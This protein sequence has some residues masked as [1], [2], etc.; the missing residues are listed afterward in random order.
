MCCQRRAREDCAYDIDSRGR[1]GLEREMEGEVDGWLDNE[2]TVP[3]RRL[4][5]VESSWGGVWIGK[6]FWTVSGSSSK[7]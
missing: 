2:L 7:A 4:P 1:E 6:R 3:P 5:K